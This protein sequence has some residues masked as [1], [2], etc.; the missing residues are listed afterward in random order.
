MMTVTKL[1]GFAFFVF[2]LPFLLWSSE[3]DAAS[4]QEKKTEG[5]KTILRRPTV[6]SVQDMV[7]K[8]SVKE[9][10][11][12]ERFFRDNGLWDEMDRC[13][14]PDSRVEISWFRGSGHGFVEASKGLGEFG[15]APHKI[16][17]TEVWTNGD[18]AVAIMLITLQIRQDY[19]GYP[20]DL[21]S[22]SKLVFRT[23]RIGG[24]WYIVAFDV[25][26]EKDA[27]V[28]AFPNSGINIPA[29]EIAKYRPSYGAMIY[30]R[31]KAGLPIAEDLPGVD[32][33]DLVEKL[34]RAADDWL[35][36]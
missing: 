5:Y 25:I 6:S 34:Y 13:Y 4:I 16:Y 21:L 8:A 30:M 31:K 1:L 2:M 17:N 32:R 24:Q 26:Y 7:D 11:E 33:P 36:E 19:D 35:S 12:A 10:L 18:K 3:A 22:D 9:L 27:M 20:V 28:P 14:A 23:Q 15:F 29:E